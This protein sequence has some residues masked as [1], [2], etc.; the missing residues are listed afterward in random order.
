MKA[1]I[2]FLL[3][4]ALFGIIFPLAFAQQNQ[5]T[6]QSDPEIETLKKRISVLESKLQTV[7][8]TEKMEL[9]TK[10]ADAN[11]KLLNAEID[12]YTRQLKDA[13]DEWLRTWSLWFVGIIGFLVLIV[14]GAF[15]FWLRSRAD[16]LIANSVEKSLTGFEAAVSQVDTLKNELKEA[17]GQ[18]NILQDQIR[19]LEKEHAVSVLENANEYYLRHEHFHTEQ[20][21]AL[22][23]EILLQVF[24]DET[25][26]IEIRCSAAE[27]LTV[28]KSSLFVASLLKFLNSVFDSDFD[29]K[30]SIDGE[31]LPFRFLSFIGRIHTDDAHQ[32]LK[33]FLNRLLT[34]D[35]TH[36]HLFLPWT[37]YFLADIDIELELKDSV[38][39]MRKVIPDLENP[40]QVPQLLIRLAEYFDIFN[41]PEGIKEILTHHASDEMPDVETRCLDLL[42]NHDPEFVEKWKAKKATANAQTEES[43]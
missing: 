42:P 31:R 39:I 17:M 41:A 15:W 7:E 22:K 37:T 33:K 26:L 32:G 27:V 36:K 1:F 11:A 43:E 29:W 6:Q 19:I 14:G 23:E 38:S 12:K 25:R 16:Q 4:A 24:E 35:L 21:K 5:N 9:E 10:L 13:N 30:T 28:R 3:F 18:V 2:A 8:N 34:E 40:Q 20:I